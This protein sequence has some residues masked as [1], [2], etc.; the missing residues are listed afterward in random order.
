VRTHRLERNPA[1]ITVTIGEGREPFPGKIR[2][3]GSDIHLALM[4]QLIIVGGVLT[5]ALPF[6]EI[7]P[8]MPPL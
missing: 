1:V 6:F 2:Q 5:L 4:H 7:W 8:K 3:Q